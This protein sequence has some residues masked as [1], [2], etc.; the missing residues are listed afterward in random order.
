MVSPLPGKYELEAWQ[1]GGPLAH[2]GPRVTVHHFLPEGGGELLS[3][4]SRPK[5]GPTVQLTSFTFPTGACLFSSK[6]EKGRVAQPSTSGPV[7]FA[8]ALALSAARPRRE[9]RHPFQAGS[10]AR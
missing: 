7:F 1:T 3:V 10:G 8:G 6:L 9:V 2:A 4:A 5:R